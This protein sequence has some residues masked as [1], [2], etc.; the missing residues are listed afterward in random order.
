MWAQR[1]RSDEKYRKERQVNSDRGRTG[2]M[3]DRAGRSKDGQELPEAGRVEDE[4]LPR[5]LG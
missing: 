5:G 3:E 1:H 2:V 4:Y